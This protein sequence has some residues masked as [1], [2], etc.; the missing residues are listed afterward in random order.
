MASLLVLLQGA[1][2]FVAPAAVVALVGFAHCGRRDC[3]GESTGDVRVT[4]ACTWLGSSMQEQLHAGMQRKKNLVSFF[5][6]GWRSGV[7]IPSPT[8]PTVKNR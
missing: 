1:L 4:A 8:L 3:G 6:E 2:L 5:F 7:V